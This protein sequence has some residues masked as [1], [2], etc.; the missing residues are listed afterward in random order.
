MVKNYQIVVVLP[1]EREK[2]CSKTNDNNKPHQGYVVSH[3]SVSQQ[4]ED[5]LVNEYLRKHKVNPQPILPWDC[6]S[7]TP[8]GSIILTKEKKVKKKIQK[9]TRPADIPFRVQGGGC[10]VSVSP[11][12]P[13]FNERK[14]FEQCQQDKNSLR[15]PKAPPLINGAALV[16]LWREQ[17]DSQI[18]N[19][20]VSEMKRRGDKKE[21]MMKAS[22]KEQWEKMLLRKA[23]ASVVQ[24]KRQKAREK[25]KELTKEHMIRL[26]TL[27]LA[28]ED[29]HSAAGLLR[30]DRPRAEVRKRVAQWLSLIPVLLFLRK[31]LDAKSEMKATRVMLKLLVPLIYR[32]RARRSMNKK[33]EMLLKLHKSTVSP[34]TPLDFKRNAIFRLW[35]DNL[36]EELLQ[37]VT[38]RAYLCNEHVTF[39]GDPIPWAGVVASGK[40][41]LSIMLPPSG[42]NTHSAKSRKVDHG[43]I[44]SHREEADWLGWTA[45][46]C[47]G[48]TWEFSA[49]CK[50]DS[51]LW[52]ILKKD[53]DALIPRLPKAAQEGYFSLVTS[54]ALSTTVV[55][56]TASDLQN[57]APMFRDVSAWTE[58]DL[59]EVVSHMKPSVL[60]DCDVDGLVREGDFGQDFHFIS[61][62]AVLIHR[63]KYKHSFMYPTQQ[64]GASTPLRRKSRAASIATIKLSP[65]MFGLDTSQV[66]VDVLQPGASFGE[67]SFL[68]P[69]PRMAT[70]IPIG[71]VKVWVLTRSD[72]Q[73]LLL[74]FPDRS[75][76][77]RE[78]TSIHRQHRL[79]SLTKKGFGISHPWL[80][81]LSDRDCS[82]L[83]RIA[84]PVT[85]CPGEEVVLKSSHVDYVFL[86]LSGS[87]EDE[88]AHHSYKIDSDKVYFGLNEAL[89]DGYR[90][91]RTL[92]SLGRTELWAFP[93]QILCNLLWS[94][95]SDESFE[96]IRR[97]SYLEIGQPF[98]PLHP[99]SRIHKADMPPPLPVRQL[100]SHL[101]TNQSKALF[102]TI[103]KSGRARRSILAFT[104]E[105]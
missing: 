28:F 59:Q 82:S 38:L 3:S 24:E 104:L 56:L 84:E 20:I 39:E 34:L 86:I 16:R 68:W 100:L 1:S 4:E 78:A 9:T 48:V 66:C 31:L 52:I 103:H 29:K 2:K 72:F 77:M 98:A 26:K 89:V 70:C 54:S 25:H 35:P 43:Y 92:R 45:L 96:E 91:P 88:S 97:E 76:P 73:E 85:L 19:K 105:E 40:L 55:P 7:A 49:Q 61:Q 23:R 32:N 10:S 102:S 46:C 11:F 67:Y 69:E 41:S 15:V 6:H 37:K 58:Q 99:G 22:M 65:E 8:G 75:A 14:A 71:V 83:L 42:Y 51:L 57:S 74:K 21:I 36:L 60:F 33:K 50:T 81:C 90:W 13:T 95:L 64:S 18:R 27:H 93:A 62:G 94:R 17:K 79:L 30:E 63:A 47:P 5:N 53:F 44:F 87:V 80:S 12:F 101:K